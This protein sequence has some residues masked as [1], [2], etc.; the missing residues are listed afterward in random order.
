MDECNGL[1]DGDGNVERGRGGWSLDLGC[2]RSTRHPPHQHRLSTTCAHREARDMREADLKSLLRAPY[3]IGLRAELV[4][5]S[6]NTMGY[7]GTVL[8][9]GCSFKPNTVNRMKYGSQHTTNAP[10]TAARVTVA[11]CSRR[12]TAVT[13]ETTVVLV[14]GLFLQL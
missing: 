6:H 2:S 12:A 11:L 5:P 10:I 3:R 1:T 7:S 9:S 13:L 8:G 4:Y 14:E